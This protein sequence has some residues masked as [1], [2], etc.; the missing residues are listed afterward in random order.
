MAEDLLRTLRAEATPDASTVPP[1]SVVELIRAEDAPLLVR[2]YYAGGDPGPITAAL[3]HVPELLEV[4]MPFLGAALGASGIDWPTKEIVILRTSARY[5]CRYC[6]AS[7]TPVALDSGWSHE[8]VHALR[9]ERSPEAVF[10]LRERALIAWVDAVAS[11]LAVPT[12]TEQSVKEHFADHEIVE[13]T[14]LVGATMLLNRMATALRLPVDA[15]TIER[16]ATEG[17]AFT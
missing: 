10:S 12:E 5:S 7:H 15:S 3:A 16:L 2:P 14:V 6:I 1:M 13:L 17:M 11:D 4:A 9:C 8:Q